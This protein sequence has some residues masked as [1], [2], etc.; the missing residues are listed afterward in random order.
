MAIY[1]E[2]VD[3]IDSNKVADEFVSHCNN[4]RRKKQ[5]GQVKQ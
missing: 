4:Y 2:L 3:K 1:P 5:L